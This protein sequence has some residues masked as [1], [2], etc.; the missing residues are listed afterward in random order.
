MSNL[1]ATLRQLAF[2]AELRIDDAGAP[3]VPLTA[4]DLRALLLDDRSEP[5]PDAPAVAEADPSPRPLDPR[6]VKKL[7]LAAW[8][9]GRQAERLVDGEQAS[10]LRTRVE[11][12]LEL[13]R[14]E[15]VEILDYSGKPY[16]PGEV[17][18]DVIGSREE[19]QN[20]VITSMREPRVLYRGALVVRGTPIIEDYKEGS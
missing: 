9:L 18:D 15:E 6:F 19:K 17:W 3:L 2:A 12:L 8:R 14:N 11:I 13:L 16:D 1:V 7:A 10:R 5:P 20:P 4:E